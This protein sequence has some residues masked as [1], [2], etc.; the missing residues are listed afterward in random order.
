[1]TIIAEWATRRGGIWRRAS[2]TWARVMTSERPLKIAERNGGVARLLIRHPMWRK[3]RA[4]V[5][6]SK[7]EA[8]ELLSISTS[9]SKQITAAA[10]RARGART[11]SSSRLVW[12]G[13]SSQNPVTGTHWW[14][15]ALSCRC[16]CHIT[17]FDTHNKAL[18]LSSSLRICR[19]A[20]RVRLPGCYYSLQ[21]GTYLPVTYF[22]SAPFAAIGVGKRAGT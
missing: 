14:H 22:S 5:V 12:L 16:T 10:R 2:Y 3:A 6:A 21:L 4:V 9:S 13:P 11:S 17:K 7:I 20:L 8:L 18:S 1:M 19:Q 15:Y